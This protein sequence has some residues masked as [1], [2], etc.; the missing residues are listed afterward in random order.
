MAFLCP[1]FQSITIKF[2]VYVVISYFCNIVTAF[3]FVSSWSS[4]LTTWWK[5]GIGCRRLNL[6]LLRGFFLLFGFWLNRV[7]IAYFFIV[8]VFHM[9]C[10]TK[11]IISSYSPITFQKHKFVCPQ[12]GSRT[13][14][15]FGKE[16]TRFRTFLSCNL[17][18]WIHALINNTKVK[19]WKG[20]SI[21]HVLKFLVIF[22]HSPIVVTFTKWDF[23]IYLV[24]WSFG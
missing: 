14:D 10:A 8:C 6:L 9:G 1:Q 19:H 23:C 3:R 2:S 15:D 21:N 24:K 17:S 5:I 13:I 7:K 22:T 18:N 16:K 12:S 11:I 20:S 4:F